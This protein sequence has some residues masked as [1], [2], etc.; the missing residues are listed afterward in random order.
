[1]KKRICKIWDV[2]IILLSVYTVGEFFIELV[3]K[4][5][6]S[7]QSGLEDADFVICILF[8][9]TGSIIWSRPIQN[10]TA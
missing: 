8:W 1:M 9:P 6:K 7:V 2:L 10:S 3:T 4:I 5:P